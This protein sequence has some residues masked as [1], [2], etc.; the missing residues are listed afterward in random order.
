MRKLFTLCLLVF[1]LSA[2]AQWQQTG[3]KVRYVNGLGIPTRD[4]VA[5]VAADSSQIVIRP[6]DSSLYVKYKRTWLRVGGG[7]VSGTINYIPKFTSS[8]AIGNSQIF[9]NGTNVGIGTASPAQKLDVNG[10]ARVTTEMRSKNTAGNISYFTFEENTNANSATFISGDARTTGNL[11]LWTNSLERIRID[12][13]GNVGIGY[14]APAAKLAVNGTTLINTNTDNGVDALQVSGSAIASTLK[15]NTSGQTVSISSYYNG[16]TGRHIWIGGGGLSSNSSSAENTAIGVDAMLN[17]TSGYYNSALGANALKANTTGFL[18]VAF[19][20]YA[21]LTN[22]T[23][24]RNMAIGQSALEQSNSSDNAA[25]GSQTL[26]SLTSGGRNVGIGSNAL[27]YAT[28]GSSN[29]AV[30]TEAGKFISGGSNNVTSGTSIY[31]GDDTRASA[32]GNSNEIVIGHNAIGQG[33]NTAIIGNSSITKTFLRGATMVNTTTDNGVDELQV[34][35]SIQG[36]GFNQAYTA[37]T[38]T[39]TAANTD[40]F[41]DCTSGTFTVN[42]FTAVGNTGRILIIKN[43]GTGTI[44]VDPNGSQTIDGAT[45]YSLATQYATVQI[46]S[47][48]TN[49]K[50]IS[51][52]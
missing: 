44:T 34:N 20:P 41:I 42:L 37:R 28:T 45:T 32:N 46:V 38:T 24:N 31:L 52:F 39:Y 8:T 48:G 7:T 50:I 40:Y 3:S 16:G 36:T 27:F 14:T 6:A 26:I 2:S 29:V 9:D 19:G 12:N 49:W 22:T 17:N 30:G 33:S 18:N 35:G 10:I 51:K 1:T 21:L 13:N 4:T 11:G 5:G 47:D 15:F 23:G 43:S 25:V